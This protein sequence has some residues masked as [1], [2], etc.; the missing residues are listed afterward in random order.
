LFSIGNVFRPSVPSCASSVCNIICVSQF[1]GR[2]AEEGERLG[3]TV[4][5]RRPQPI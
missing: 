5:A 2:A 1:C 3:R 4:P